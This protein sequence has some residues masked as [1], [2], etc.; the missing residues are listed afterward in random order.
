MFPLHSPLIVSA[1]CFLSTALILWSSNPDPY[2]R[3]R[4]HLLP[5]S[6]LRTEPHWHQWEQVLSLEST[7]QKTLSWQWYVRTTDVAGDG[8]NCSF[9]V[10]QCC[11]RLCVCI[12]MCTCVLV[13]VD[14]CAV[15][16]RY[17]CKYVRTYVCTCVC[18]MHT[19]YLYVA[20]LVCMYKYIL[21]TYIRMCI[22]PSA[23]VLKHM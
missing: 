1:F 18:S 6:G 20:C 7:H 3:M 13:Y 16:C 12:C 19:E 8:Q 11:T 21:R 15:Q 22:C 14:V 17:I 9:C 10:F 23:N 5:S 4:W 2:S